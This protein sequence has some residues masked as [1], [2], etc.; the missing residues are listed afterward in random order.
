MVVPVFIGAQNVV[1][2]RETH[3]DNGSGNFSQGFEFG[4]Q[5]RKPALLGILTGGARP[6]L[7]F[8]AL[9]V[10]RSVIRKSNKIPVAAVGLPVLNSYPTMGAFFRTPRHG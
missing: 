7:Q 4:E 2:N 8:G 1:A 3:G 9:C 5:R 6:F 10:N